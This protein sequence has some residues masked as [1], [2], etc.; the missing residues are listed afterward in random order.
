MRGCAFDDLLRRQVGVIGALD[1]DVVD[2]A[3]D[4]ARTDVVEKR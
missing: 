2:R 1:F 4:V 3:D